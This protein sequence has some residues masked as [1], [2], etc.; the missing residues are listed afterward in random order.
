M[1]R[2]KG[3]ANTTVITMINICLRVWCQL[4]ENNNKCHGILTT[5][6][7]F[8]DTGEST[9]VSSQVDSS[10]G[11][12]AGD[13]FCSFVGTATALETLMRIRDQRIESARTQAESV[14]KS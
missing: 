2:R 3:D 1:K 5:E 9:H 6:F 7:P 13:T 12:G 10:T 11:G 4:T 14:I 8:L